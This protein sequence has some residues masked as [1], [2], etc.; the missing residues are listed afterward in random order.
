MRKILVIDDDREF[1]RVAHVKLE[2]TGALRVREENDPSIALHTA[3]KFK[4][5]L[6]LMDIM[7]PGKE[8]SELAAD[9]ILDPSLERTPIIFLT[10]LVS[11]YDVCDGGSFISGGRVCLPK[12]VDWRRLVHCIHRMIEPAAVLPLAGAGP[13]AYAD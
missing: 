8:G 9:I 13:A 3:R 12:P 1:T 2:G 10:R 7:M 5:D 6:I 4:P 11:R